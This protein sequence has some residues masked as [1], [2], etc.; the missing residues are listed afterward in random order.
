LSNGGFCGPPATNFGTFLDAL[1][2]EV[3]DPIALRAR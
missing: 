2:D 3:H 1:L